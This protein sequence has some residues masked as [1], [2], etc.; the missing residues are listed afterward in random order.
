MEAGTRIEVDCELEFRDFYHALRWYSL[1]R[2]WWLYCILIG[3]PTVAILSTFRNSDSDQPSSRLEAVL[4]TLVVP[5]L[6]VGL[7]YWS[8]YRNARR[9]FKTNSLLRERRHYVFSEEGLETS[10]PSSSSKLAWA[11]LHKILETS[12]SFLFFTSN[13]VMVVFPKGA[14]GSEERIQALRVL[15]RQQLGPKA[16][17]KKRQAE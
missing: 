12:E 4:P 9:Q 14:L 3:L 10:S 11:V 8:I 17:M 16:K 15:I 2:L 13:V 1:R 6:L 5:I 7:Y